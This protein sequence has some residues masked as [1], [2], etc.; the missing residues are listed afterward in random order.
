[1]TPHRATFPCTRCGAAISENARFCGM[2]GEARAA[3]PSPETTLRTRLSAL[4]MRLRAANN[5]VPV[6]LV[7]A[8]SALALDRP[9]AAPH[10]V[11]L[12]EQG[13][14]TRA[15]AN[16]VLGQARLAAGPSTRDA[17]VRLA[18]DPT[19]SDLLAHISLEVAPPLAADAEQTADGVIAALMRAD[20]VLFCLSA[21]QLLSATE[22]RLISALARLTDAPKALIT[23]RMD[24]ADTEEDQEDIYARVEGFRVELHDAIGIA[25]DVFFDDGQ[26]APPWT[27]WLAQQ[28]AMTNAAHPARW[29]PRAQHL[30]TAL[31]AILDVSAPTSAPLPPVEILT[32][33]LAEAHAAARARAHVT[34]DEGLAR[35]RADLRSHLEGMT[36]EQR[37][38]EGAAELVVRTEGLLRECT[39]TWCVALDEALQSFSLP[40]PPANLSADPH[41]PSITGA[42]PHLER[43]LPESSVGLMAAAIGL[44][45]GVLLLPIGGPSVVAVGVGLT[46]GSYATARVLRDRRN[47][48][49]LDHHADT[50]DQWLRE[51]GVRAN[52]WLSDDLDT[53]HE[54]MAAQLVDLHA[55]ANHH[56]DLHHPTALAE[57][58]RDLRDALRQMAN[59]P[60]SSTFPTIDVQT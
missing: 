8:L 10:V 49:L 14:G 45:A 28:R 42:L 24:V 37:S 44:S 35:L 1:M 9:P 29:T 31:T 34:L 56:R 32:Q 36:A 41:I 57:D 20:I 17:A 4:T 60:D 26:G 47:A 51:V 50:L 33:A 27:D 40:L 53:A 39:R 18:V 19:A 38:H 23:H 21:V 25:P 22:R 58:A 55:Q 2:C 11:I 6:D 13:R 54:R 30:L 48:Q 15:L 16:R 43:R 12:G 5:L 3:D 46:A 52:D 59:T 7:D